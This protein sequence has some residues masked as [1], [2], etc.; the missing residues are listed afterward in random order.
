MLGRSADEA[1]PDADHRLRHAHADCIGSRVSS[2][3]FAAH[4][5]ARGWALVG[6]GN[7]ETDH[8]FDGPTDGQAYP[9]VDASTNSV[10]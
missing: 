8:G 3:D 4:R 7:D 10:A 5:R 9:S 1:G 6:S 2:A